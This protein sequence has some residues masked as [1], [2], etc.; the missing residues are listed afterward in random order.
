MSASTQT[1]NKTKV[2]LL[3]DRT[4][5]MQSVKKETIEG[6]NGYLDELSKNKSLG[7]LKLHVTQFDS[8]GIDVLAD[9]VRLPN[10]PRLS[11]ESYV[12]RAT[13]P[14]YDAIGKTIRAVEDRT[15]GS[16]VLFVTL[17]DGQENASREWDLSKVKALILEKEQKD[18]WTFSYIGV[19]LD[20]WQAHERLAYG[21]AGY[22]NV[23]RATRGKNTKKVYK[24]MAKATV[25]RCS[26][27][28][29]QSLS[30]VYGGQQLDHYDD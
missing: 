2:V 23:L 13:T 6:F 12:P 17:T 1:K 7:S 16:K 26:T 18:K 21:T 8:E 27:A 3:L 5:S 29:G 24:L 25:M 20:A 14:L 28:G 22:S 4:G 15:N 19:G 10:V 11:H 30:S 9:M